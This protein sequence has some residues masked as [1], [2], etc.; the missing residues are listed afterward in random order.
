MD[1]QLT[2]RSFIVVVTEG[3]V[4]KVGSLVA[5]ESVVI[6]KD[7]KNLAGR[8]SEPHYLLYEKK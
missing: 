7:P 2:L 8:V 6:P 5:S 1:N 4:E 3:K